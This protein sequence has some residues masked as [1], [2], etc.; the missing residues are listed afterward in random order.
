[1]QGRDHAASCF[2]C[3]VLTWLSWISDAELQQKHQHLIYIVI[4]DY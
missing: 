2:V 3:T 1:M 4:Q